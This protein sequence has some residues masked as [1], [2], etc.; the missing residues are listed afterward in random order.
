MA[1][2]Y[3]T[4]A[5][6]VRLTQSI[7][8]EIKKK[9]SKVQISLLCPGPVK[10]NF[11]NVANVKFN[12]PSLESQTVAQYAIDKF[13]E[14]KFLIVPGG[15]IKTAK[16]LAKITPDRVVAKVNYHMQETKRKNKEKTNEKRSNN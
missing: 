14:G 15:I 13:L 2:Y 3:S 1:T 9:K 5:Y 4:K 10:T 16:I 11:N 12:I 6:I 8:E 7:R